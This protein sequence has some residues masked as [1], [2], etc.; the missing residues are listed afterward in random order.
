MH[1]EQRCQEYHIKSDEEIE[2]GAILW[3]AVLQNVPD[4]QGQTVQAGPDP[5]K[6]GTDE[7]KRGQK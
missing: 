3:V 2:L 4:D 1:C 5:H 6:L 7:W